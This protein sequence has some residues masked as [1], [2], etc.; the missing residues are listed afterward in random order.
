MKKV[1][2][3]VVLFAIGFAGKAQQYLEMTDY[4]LFAVNKV[5]KRIGY[6]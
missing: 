6:Y 5:E 1:L 4:H 3:V 2:L